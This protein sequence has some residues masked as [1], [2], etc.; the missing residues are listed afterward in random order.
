MRS[1]LFAALAIT[2]LGATMTFKTT[3]ANALPLTAPS[4]LRDAAD[5]IDLTQDVRWVCRHGYNGKRC[6]WSPSPRRHW[7]HR[8]R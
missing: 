7:G 8:Y 2:A 3:D 6:W 1:F 4:G 5:S